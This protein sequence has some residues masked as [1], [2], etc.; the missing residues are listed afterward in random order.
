MRTVLVALGLTLLITTLPSC[1]I[2]PR[3]AREWVA[4]PAMDTSG[5]AL[6]Q[7]SLRKLHGTR[8]AASGGDGLS[9]GGGCACGQ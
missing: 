2:V 7:R 3:Y 5:D 1:V 6:A 8:E 4:D 9:A